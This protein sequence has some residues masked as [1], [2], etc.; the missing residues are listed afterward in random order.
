MTMYRMRQREFILGLHRARRSSCARSLL[1]ARRP[2]I[3]RRSSPRT[4]TRSAAQPTTVAHY[5]LAVIEQLERDAARLKARLRAHQ[6]QSARRLR[7]HRHRLSDRSAAARRELLGFGGADRQHL[8][9][10]RDGR[11][12]ARE[13]VGGGGAARPASAASSRT[14]CS[15]ARRSSATCGSA[16]ASCS[17]AASCRR[18]AIRSRSSTR[19]RSAARRSARRRRSSPPSTTRRSA[20]SSTPRTTCSR[21][22]SRCSATR[23][24]R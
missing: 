22:C 24:A 11:L 4:R 6:P 5:L 21:S 1:D 19:A 18:S 15:G 13:R 2:R 8:R 3:A 16:T 17:A 12:P 20:T 23:R 9:Q 10:H 7:D 14:C